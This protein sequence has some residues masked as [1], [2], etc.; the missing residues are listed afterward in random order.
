MWLGISFE[1]WMAIAIPVV[2]AV[3]IGYLQLRR[4]TH[5][6]SIALNRSANLTS[7]FAKEVPN[8]SV[9]Y[10]DQNVKDELIWLSGVI[11]NDGHEDVGKSK[12]TRFPVLKLG[13][14][15][16]WLEFEIAKDAGLPDG[17][18]A[19]RKMVSATEVQISWSLLKAGEIIPFSALIK[20]PDRGMISDLRQGKGLSTS[21]RIENVSLHFLG[22]L[23]VGEPRTSQALFMVTFMIAAIALYSVFV[24]VPL[25]YSPHDSYVLTYKKGLS[26]QQTFVQEQAF[27]NQLEL[28]TTDGSRLVKVNPSTNLIVVSGTKKIDSRPIRY[29][30]IALLVTILILSAIIIGLVVREYKRARRANPSMTLLSLLNRQKKTPKRRPAS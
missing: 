21:S 5:R 29:V 2:I 28:R 25:L 18:D 30:M 24:L 11:S 9:L 7:E 6:I 3:I 17:V 16:E 10:K 14:G 20:T 12:I 1:S 23:S 15:A 8:I 27:S 22:E 4:R 13:E 26:G 19:E